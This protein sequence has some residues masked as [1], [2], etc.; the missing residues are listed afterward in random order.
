M[1]IFILIAGNFDNGPVS[2]TPTVLLKIQNMFYKGDLLFCILLPVIVK[3]PF[4]VVI[5]ELQKRFVSV[6]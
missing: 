1:E 6:D 4:E 5:A 2:N 3:H